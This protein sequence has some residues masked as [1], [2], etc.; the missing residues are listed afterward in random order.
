MEFKYDIDETP[1]SKFEWLI[2][3]IQHVFAMFGS[4]VLVPTLIGLDPSVALFT[5]GTGTIIYSIIT[6]GKVPVF[7]GSSFAYIGILAVL[8]DEGREH[9]NFAV[10]TVGFIYVIIAIIIT[11]F[12]N[13]WIDKILPPVVMGPLIIVIGLSLAPVAVSNSGL[14]ADSLNIKWAFISLSTLAVTGFAL[15]KGTKFTKT[16]PI[17]IGIIYGYIIS[18]ILG[19]VDLSVYENIK[20]FVIPDFSFYAINSDVI[21]DLG[22]VLALIPLVL[23]TVSEHIGDHAVSSRLTGKNFFIDPGLNVTLLAD[24]LATLFAG[25]VG[26]PVNT[27]YAENTG[28]IGLT[29]VASVKVIQLAAIIAIIIAFVNPI[30]VFIGSIPL[31]VMGGISMVLFGLIAQNGITTLVND[32]TD[33]THPRNTI[34]IATILVI[35]IGGAIIDFSIG[36]IDIS[37]EKMSLAAVIGIG[38]HLM[39]PSKSVSSKHVQ[40]N[41]E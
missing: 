8:M 37:L 9:A 11:I 24:G 3:S 17:I 31:P 41:G 16:I 21:F 7:I 29:R 10:I 32:H 2:L 6:K 36:N 13:N 35:G 20:F 39:L 19:E 28:V 26:G 33:Y 34:I 1:N 27:T 5:A 4:T 23:V 14:S 12:G 30:T 40:N 25:F 38:L 15:L 18:I 22:I